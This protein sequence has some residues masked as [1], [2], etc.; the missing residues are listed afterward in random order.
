M[1]GVEFFVVCQIISD[2]SVALARPLF[3]SLAIQN[4]DHASFVIDQ[5]FPLQGSSD[6]RYG[7]PR[8]AEHVG[9][10]LLGHFERFNVCS[11]RTDQEPARESLLIFMR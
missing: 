8:A 5:L 2:D 10:E 4:A 1:R 3:E 11:V 6:H 7:G 9:E